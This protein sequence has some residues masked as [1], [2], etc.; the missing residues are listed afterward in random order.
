MSEKAFGKL[1]IL[2]QRLRRAYPTGMMTGVQVVIR[3]II[4]FELFNTKPYHNYETWS[5]GYEATDGTYRVQAEDLDECIRRL[6]Y[7]RD[8]KDEAKGVDLLLPNEREGW[9]PVGGWA[10]D[11]TEGS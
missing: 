7:L 9:L 4:G 3:K 5:D 2:D 8:H 1:N 11:V 10:F 6:A